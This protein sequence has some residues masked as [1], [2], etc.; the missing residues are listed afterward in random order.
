MPLT[1]REE[2]ETILTLH[3]DLG[4]FVIRVLHE[5]NSSIQGSIE[6]LE[7]NQTLNFRSE[8]EMMKLID[9]AVHR[10]SP[11]DDLRSWKDQE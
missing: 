6:W 2:K 1:E 11:R 9:E 5:Q 10:K 4:T 3:E 8:W 7:G